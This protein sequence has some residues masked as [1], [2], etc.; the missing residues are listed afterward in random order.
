[1]N[2]VTIIGRITKELELRQVGGDK[3]LLTFSIAYND[4]YGDNEHT[5][6]FDITAW[7]RQ[8]EVIAQYFKKGQRIAVV[9]RLKQD[10]YEAKDGSGMRSRVNI[11]LREFSFI[12]PKGYT[13]AASEGVPPSEAPMQQQ[14]ANNPP[15]MDDDE[16]PF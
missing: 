11:V 9:G 3:T 16:V 14:E 6:F 13:A 5:S 1:M 4:S 7:G 10:R 2:Q 8:A 15:L 12:E